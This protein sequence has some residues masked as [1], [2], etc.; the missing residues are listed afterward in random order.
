MWRF[1]R[2]ENPESETA[3]E[4]L[5]K[6]ADLTGSA[7]FKKSKYEEMVISFQFY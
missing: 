3:A 1:R 5:N 4:I 6:A 2:N 7:A